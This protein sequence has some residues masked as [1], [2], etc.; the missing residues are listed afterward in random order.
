MTTDLRRHRAANPVV[1]PLVSFAV[2]QFDS[3]ALWMA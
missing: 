2:I 1:E 3:R